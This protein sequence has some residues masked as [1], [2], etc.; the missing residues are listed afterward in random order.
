MQDGLRVFWSSIHLSYLSVRMAV[1]E[2][3]REPVDH[4]ITTLEELIKAPSSKVSIF[5]AIK[6]TLL[7]YKCSVAERQIML[8]FS[9]PSLTHRPTRWTSTCA[10]CAVVEPLRTDFCCATAATTAITS[11]V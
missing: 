11:S 6:L 5:I 8:S 2:V 4:E 1:T 7:W 10:W 9:L 3:K